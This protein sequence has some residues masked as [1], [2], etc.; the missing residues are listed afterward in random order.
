MLKVINGGSK[1]QTRQC[2]SRI[3]AL[4]HYVTLP[5]YYVL[6]RIQSAFKKGEHDNMITHLCNK[7]SYEVNSGKSSLTLSTCGINMFNQRSS[8]TCIHVNTQHIHRNTLSYK[9]TGVD[10]LMLLSCTHTYTHTYT[11]ILFF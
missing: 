10:T 3:C 8:V 2:D 7:K 6:R 9:N 5:L 1:L 4:S 11:Q